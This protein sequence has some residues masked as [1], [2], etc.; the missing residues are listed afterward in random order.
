MV[1]PQTIANTGVTFVVSPAGRDPAERAVPA[2][3]PDDPLGGHGRRQETERDERRYLVGQDNGD[4]DQQRQP[5]DGP[6]RSTKN[7]FV[8][9]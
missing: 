3:E 2:D 7:S 4:A 6:S 1:S 8:I 9:P 5:E